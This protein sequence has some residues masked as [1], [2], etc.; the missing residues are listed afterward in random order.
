[1]TLKKPSD[2]ALA[3]LPASSL[4]PSDPRALPVLTDAQLVGAEPVPERMASGVDVAVERPAPNES[5]IET[6]TARALAA[7]VDEFELAGLL[8]LGGWARDSLVTAE[9]FDAARARFGGM[10]VG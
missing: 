7:K 9:A 6:V 3:S 10:G 1:M 4:A 2:E 5:P 8:V